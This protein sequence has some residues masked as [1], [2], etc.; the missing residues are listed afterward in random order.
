[1]A[2]VYIYTKTVDVDDE[3]WMNDTNNIAYKIMIITKHI[4]T[5]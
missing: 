2:K 4:F 5:G 3:I 1:M